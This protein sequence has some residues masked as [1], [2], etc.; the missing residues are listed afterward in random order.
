[1]RDVITDNRKDIKAA[2]H[3][4]RRRK[5]A[6]YLPVLDISR[7]FAMLLHGSRS[8]QQQGWESHVVGEVKKSR[9]HVDANAIVPVQTQAAGVK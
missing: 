7:P 6:A 2:I 4:T 9:R 8:Q 5:L 3:V 1:M